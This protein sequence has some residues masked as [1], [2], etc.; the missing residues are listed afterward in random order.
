[1]ATLFVRQRPFSEK[2]TV[3]LGQDGLIE[4]TEVQLWQVG[5]ETIGEMTTT[6]AVVAVDGDSNRVPQIGD[7]HPRYPLILRCSGVE[8][9]RSEDGPT[10]FNV[11]VT[12][13]TIKP[14]ENDKWDIQLD[15]TGCERTEDMH[16]GYRVTSGTGDYSKRVPVANSANDPFD[17]TEK[18][19]YYDEQISVQYKTRSIDGDLIA[20][21]R[22]KVSKDSITLTVYGQTRSFASGNI[23]L[24]K[25]D[26]STTVGNG[27][28]FWQVSLMLHYRSTGW[29]HKI[30]DRG[31]YFLD[32]EEDDGHREHKPILDAKK[33]PVTGPRLLDG[34]GN[35]L[36]MP[37][38]PDTVQV[39]TMDYDEDEP[40]NLGVLLSGI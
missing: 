27:I 15:V 3:A 6:G 23:K 8:P 16:D 31:F 21:L 30:V 22:G 5:V 40:A 25:A 20:S 39:V 38:P 4:Y 33:D 1:M 26:Y 29:T 34:S 10:V 18:R 36:D 17:P 24:A 2:T 28:Q 35:V 11:T 32:T 12:Y 14:G 37:D 19:T 7:L 13:T 9:S